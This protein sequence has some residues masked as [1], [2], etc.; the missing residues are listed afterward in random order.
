MVFPKQFLYFHFLTI[1]LQNIYIYETTGEAGKMV[2]I[3]SM[4]SISD[5]IHLVLVKTDS[6]GETTLLSSNFFEWRPLLTAKQGQMKTSI[7]MMGTGMCRSFILFL[8]SHLFLIRMVNDFDT[9]F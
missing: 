1:I 5:P 3:A 8:Y 2:D 7:E 4:L 6:Y 9:L